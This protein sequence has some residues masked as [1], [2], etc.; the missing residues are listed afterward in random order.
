MSNFKINY[1]IDLGTTNSVISRMNNSQVEIIQKDSSFLFPSCFY[2]DKKNREF[3]GVKAYSYLGEK[4]NFK[5]FKAFMGTDKK[6]YCS[7]N[8]KNYTPEDLSAKI[9]V[10][11]KNSIK[12]D[13]NFN[14]VIITIPA[15]FDQTQVEATNRAAKLAG[16]SYCELL[17]EP[18]AASMAYLQKNKEIDGKWL[19]FDLGGGTFDAAILEM[20]DKV[21]AI[22]NE[23]KA[24]SGDNNLGGKLFDRAIFEKII[25]PY[26]DEKYEF[27]NQLNNQENKEKLYKILK[28]E[29]ESVKKMLSDENSIDFIPDCS[30]IDDN[31]ESIDLDFQINR[32]TYE[33]SIKE[34]VDRAINICIDLLKESEISPTELISI[35]PV[36][37]P[38]YTPFI[39]E[40]IKNKIA[41]VL[42]ISINPMTS[43]SIGAAYYASTREIPLKKQK[44]NYHKLQL[45]IA[46]PSTVTNT[47]AKVG[48][49]IN[50]M[51]NDYSNYS[52][53]FLRSDNN[54]D[55]GKIPFENEGIIANLDLNENI[56]NE[57]TIEVYDDKSNLI[58]CE[59]KNLSIMQGVKLASPPM[60]SD[61]GIGVY[62]VERKQEEL[63][64]I[65]E[66]GTSLP[67]KAIEK[68]KFPNDIRPG[69]QSDNCQIQLWEGKKFTKT[70]RNN[71]M[72]SLVI[73]GKDISS[74]IPKDSEMEIS[75]KADESRRIDIEVYVPYN[76]E[77]YKKT[78]DNIAT[79]KNIPSEIFIKKIDDEI[80]RI[81][82]LE[83][84]SNLTTKDKSELLDTK[85]SF[86]K[87]KNKINKQS[88]SENINSE[89][90]NFNKKASKIDDITAA[91]KWP[92]I[93]QSLDLA[94]S[95]AENEIIR[96]ENPEI[97][98]ELDDIKK[99]MINVKKKKDYVA[100]NDLISMIRNLSYSIKG[101]S[102]E[103]WASL[104]AY[105]Y[106]EFD[107]ISWLD[108]EEA[109]NIIDN[110]GKLLDSG[111][112]TLEELKDNYF[113]LMNHIPKNEAAKIKKM[114]NVPISYK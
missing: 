51:K 64:S 6:Y 57:F 52:L 98:K 88:N 53:K 39:R 3:V 86:V 61:L 13:K 20:N 83:N 96:N 100:A 12:D 81:N 44:R 4:N 29:I 56:N 45:T 16:F 97:K 11:M 89:R 17:Q 101:E 22:A 110:V 34:Y 26:L 1:G 42:D 5:E 102:K 54:F 35:L 25:A 111:D 68:F 27:K 14:S 2:V 77:I 62:V 92:E 60:P 37:G 105:Y 69:N 103:F 32:N 8:K 114:I 50:D 10:E 109:R 104:F 76:D 18:I 67:A 93:V 49:K 79:Q 63:L 7:V 38:T 28:P 47:N 40:S 30:I 84:D 9:L 66:K 75:M 24:T 70:I 58:D 112:Y 91:L 113:N 80:E 55:T 41:N 23:G 85:K 46:S 33:N 19:V 99:E 107:N 108:Q 106:Q 36:G 65:I 82:D 90:N 94:F 43:V 59:P 87:L 78:F 15:A 48:I 72:G 73:N 74:L 71:Y 21:M 31:G 95:E